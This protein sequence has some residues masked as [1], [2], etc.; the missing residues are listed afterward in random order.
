MKKVTEYIYRGPR[1]RDIRQLIE[2]GFQRVI[3]LQSGAEEAVIEDKYEV[4]RRVAELYNIEMINIPCPAFFP[5]QDEQ[6]AL[7]TL[8]LTDPVKTYVHCHSDVDRTGYVIEAYLMQYEGKPFEQAKHDWV[9]NGRHWG[10]FW[11]SI[12]LKRWAKQAG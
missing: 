5:P 6:V 10:F 11:W 7:A 2:L 9:K 1:P 4:Q 12:F 3:C 8:L